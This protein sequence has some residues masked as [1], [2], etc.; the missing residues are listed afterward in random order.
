MASCD[1]KGKKRAHVILTAH[2]DWVLYHYRLS[3]ARAL[4]ENGYKVT[5]VCPTGNYLPKLE[6][7]GF[8]CVRWQ[9]SRKS[10]NPLREIISIVQLV[11]IYRRLKPDVVHHFTVKPNLYGTLAAYFAKVP[12]M[13]NTF[14][15]LGYLFSDDS[16]AGALRFF[17]YPFLRWA[18]NRP[19]A[20]VIFQTDS[21]RETL[22]KR[23]ILNSDKRS[24]MIRG[25]GVDTSL[26][27]RNGARPFNLPL[28]KKPVVLMASRLLWDKGI[29]EFIEMARTLKGQ[30]V[31]ADFWIVGAPDDGNPACISDR[32]IRKW[33]SEGHVEFLG[34]REDILEILR[35][36]D[37]AVLPSY[38]EGVSRFLLEAAAV[39]LPLV[40]TDID[41]C[42]SVVRSNING[43]LIPPRDSGAL[44][45]TVSKLVHDPEL[46]GQMGRASRE[47]ATREFDERL[48]HQ[49]FLKIYEELR[50][51]Y[52]KSSND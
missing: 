29:K 1:S 2:W 45:F 50:A 19:N 10:L 28:S 43:F 42:K 7:D 16:R 46:R 26:F 22:I 49:Q 9:I 24:V 5:F 30:G 38:Y 17:L 15:G 44:A 52:A 48:I 6:A 47:I 34:H 8:P 13:I 27:K 4:R 3:F 12:A 33:L 51:V 23:K 40:A 31:K 25:S 32:D 35:Q 41:G 18:V 36:A 21:D 20:A 11:G 14:T 37:I 39:G